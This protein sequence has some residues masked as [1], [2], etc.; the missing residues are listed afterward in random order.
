MRI[1]IP[2]FLA[3][4]ALALAGPLGP[5]PARGA[6]YVDSPA[7]AEAVASGKL[8]PLA[9]RLPAAPLVFAPPGFEPGRHGGELRVLMGRAQDTRMMVVY[10]Y[11]RLVGYDEKFELRP[12]LLE[13]IDVDR[14]RVFTM[15][16]REGHRW[17]DGQPFTTED[18]RYW[19]EDVVNNKA[20]FPVGP[21]LEL[22]VDGELPTIEILDARRVR[23]SWSQPN[24]FFLP[25]LAGPAPL[26]VFRPAHY[27]RQFHEK[28]ADKTKLEQAVRQARARNWAQL[29]NRLDNMYRNDNP[30]LPTLEP[31]VLQTRPP[32]ER[33]VF[34]RNPYFH[35]VDAA[36]RQLPY[37]DRVS[38][39]IAEGK[40]I[41]AK[42]GAGDA[43]LQARNLSFNLYTFLRQAA[44]KHGL[45][46]R[47]WR[48]IKGAQMALYPN[49]NAQDEAWR[50]LNRDPRFRRALSLAIDRA[51]INQVIYF[52]LGVEGANTVLPASPLFQ[53]RFRDAPFDLA[54]A[55]R[56]LD[57][58]GLARRPGEWVR[59]LPDGRPLAITVETA[60]E[61]IEQLDVL[62][63][64]KDTWQQAG[65]GLFE[66][67]WQ[68]DAFRNRVFAGQTVMSVWFGLENALPGPRT[69]PEEL[70]PTSQQQL[71]WPKWGQ[72]LETRGRSGEAI[73]EPVALE[74]MRLADEWRLAADDAARARAWARILEIHAEQ[75]FTI[76][77][78]AGVPQPVVVAGKM[79]N[80]PRDG[81]YNWDPGSFFGIYRPDGFW[82][83]DARRAAAGGG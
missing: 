32:A 25:R 55:N 43:D 20:L 79:R 63:L 37:L 49:L 81:I 7:L 82:F 80:V 41:P 77:I 39:A 71:Q 29:H 45:D 23:F 73:D 18:F 1:R 3:A 46:V 72:H 61:D 44:R 68:R 12:D 42:T 75:F 13:A 70:T 36:G 28:Y 83:D 19:W 24:P 33:F 34:A 66:K 65:V 38:M 9:Q 67:T 57:E 58:L 48:T 51:E 76:G 2:V 74:L 17:S 30:D 69:S 11:A 35:R 64:I 59:R 78:V 5:F 26:Y 60:G 27:L 10:G 54:E 22:T 62:Q 56:L 47:L 52:G 31:W 53:P 21:P 16:L 50:R 14:D 4:V 40:L 15:T 6:E 8:P